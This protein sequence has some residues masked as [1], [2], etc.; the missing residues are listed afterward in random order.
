VGVSEQSV[1]EN[2]WTKEGLTGWEKLHSVELHDLSI[3]GM[4]N[5]RRV[6]WVLH[7]I[8]QMG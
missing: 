6:R 8:Q 3:I 5:K 1:G 4:V 2:I 7:V